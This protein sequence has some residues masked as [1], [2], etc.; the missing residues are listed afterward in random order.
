MSSSYQ[1]P[2]PLNLGAPGK[3]PLKL[4]V[5]PSCVPSRQ[6]HET[7]A[8]WMARIQ[9]VTRPRLCIDED[10]EEYTD[11]VSIPLERVLKM[12]GAM[13]IFPDLNNKVYFE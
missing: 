12:D 8:E 7:Y 2:P 9:H 10:G 6:Y 1:G 3:K 5:A 4:I 13:Y 11:T